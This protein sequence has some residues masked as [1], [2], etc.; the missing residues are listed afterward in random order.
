MRKQAIFTAILLRSVDVLAIIM[1]SLLVN[2]CG[3]T[4][5]VFSR[6]NRRK[7]A[8]LMTFIESNYEGDWRKAGTDFWCPLRVNCLYKATNYLKVQN[9]WSSSWNWSWQR[10]RWTCLRAESGEHVIKK[11][12]C[13]ICIRLSNSL[14][15]FTSLASLI[16]QLQENFPGVEFLRILSRLSRVFTSSIIGENVNYTRRFASIIFRA[17][18][19]KQCC[20]NSLQQGVHVTTATTATTS[21]PVKLT[22]SFFE[23]QSALFS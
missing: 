22:S 7:V 12:I 3:V 11:V 23:T 10:R 14:M 20:E 2:K 5:F 17:A 9:G 16:F 15:Q 13:G 1:C 21:L 18:M 4:K 19:L 8:H 6:Q